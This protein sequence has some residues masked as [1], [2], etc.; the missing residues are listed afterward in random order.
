MF[1]ATVLANIVTHLKRCTSLQML[2][3]QSA[4]IV[5]TPVLGR[6]EMSQP[7]NKC[8]ESNWGSRQQGIGKNPHVSNVPAPHTS[9]MVSSH[10]DARSNNSDHRCQRP[11]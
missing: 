1:A 11:Q 5:Y 4:Y 2:A 3:L 7:Q 8:L 9:F 6:L 10:I